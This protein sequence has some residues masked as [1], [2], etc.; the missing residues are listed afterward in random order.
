MNLKS[1]NY[2]I[3][4]EILQPL[5]IHLENKVIPLVDLIRNLMRMKSQILRERSH[6]YYENE[7]TNLRERSHK[8]YENKVA[9]YKNEVANLQNGSDGKRK[10]RKRIKLSE[11]K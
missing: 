2:K 4:V 8:Y 10:K 5:I 3:R 1:Y 11:E 6:K 7:V 9:N